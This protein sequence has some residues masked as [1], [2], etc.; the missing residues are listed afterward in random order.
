MIALGSLVLA[1]K[2][3]SAQSVYFDIPLALLKLSATSLF[4][5]DLDGDD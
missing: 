4:F 3:R 5:L 1:M 2:S